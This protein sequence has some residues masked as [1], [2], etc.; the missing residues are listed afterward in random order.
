MNITL[1]STKGLLN[2]A[3]FKKA[4]GSCAI[5]KYREKGFIKPVGFAMTLGSRVSA[6]YHPRQIKELKVK[7]GVTIDNT[8]GLL[9]ESQ[10][11]KE[12]GLS[13][14]SNYRKEGLIVPVGYALSSAGL[15]P[16]YNPRQI[17][18]LKAKFK[19]IAASKSKQ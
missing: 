4:F 14:I 7:L 5:K 10:F 6:M 16:F 2:E 18:E 19:K 1:E 13:Q 8:T 9:I 3:Q 11:G 12:F 17:K 15:S